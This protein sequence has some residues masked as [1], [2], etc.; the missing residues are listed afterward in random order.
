MSDIKVGDKVERAVY[1][2]GE[3]QALECGYV[4]RIHDGCADVDVMSHHGGGP[5]IK[6]D[7]LTSLLKVSP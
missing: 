3:R 5:W 2:G 6:T 4:V 1:V 7:T